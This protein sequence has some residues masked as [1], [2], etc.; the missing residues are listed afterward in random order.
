M[1]AAM[2]IRTGRYSEQGQWLYPAVALRLGAEKLPRRIRELATA[3]YLRAANIKPADDAVEQQAAAGLARVVETFGGL[4][5]GLD[6]RSSDR[7][8]IDRAKKI[9]LDFA[10][11]EVGM[12]PVQMLLDEAAAQGVE[13]EAAFARQLKVLRDFLSGEAERAIAV[14]G[15]SARL[16]DEQFW[17]RQLRRLVA[18]A[19]EKGMR[20]L[21]EVSRRRHLY[22]SDEAVRCRRNQRARNAAMMA[23]V[24]MVNELGQEFKLSELVEKSNANPAIRR[25][26]L[27]V[28]I[29][30]F[31]AVARDVGHVGEFITLTCPSRFHAM[32]ALSGGENARFDGSTPRDAAAYLQ[33]VWSRARAQMQRE[34]VEIYGFRVAEPHHDGTPHWHGL[35]FMPPEHRL[36]FRQILALHACRADRAELD[37]RYCQT[38]AEARAVAAERRAKMAAWMEP[39]GKKPPT[40]AALMADIKIEGDFWAGQDF[41]AWK[42]RKASRRVDFVEINWARGTA[43]GYIAKYIAKNIDGKTAAGDSAGVDFEAADEADFTETAERVDAW[44]ATWGIRQFQQIGGAP[45]TV[46]RELRRIDVSADDYNDVIVRAALAADKGDWGKFSAI[47][48]GGVAARADMP[49]ALYKDDAVGVNKY[50][51]PRQKS[52]RGV[53]EKDTGL[54]KISRIHEWVSGF[55][56]GKAAPWTCVNNCTNQEPPPEKVYSEAEIAAIIRTCEPVPL[57]NEHI[58]SR[59]EVARMLEE[60]AAD[61]ERQKVEAEWLDYR[62]ELAA[63]R[64]E[65]HKL[66]GLKGLDAG[67]I[68]PAPRGIGNDGRTRI[69]RLQPLPGKGKTDADIL[70][71][72]RAAIDATAEWMEEMAAVDLD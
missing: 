38:A 30:G 23:L 6:A 50:G 46:W 65:N 34:G 24:T 40:I 18:R 53:I 28:R 52:I 57:T 4:P 71:E 43:A 2:D 48:G 33:K 54:Y 11:R 8:I 39:L 27:M 35:F 70:A 47:M 49:L 13:V 7:D 64:A 41:K 15:I 9:A 58:L 66:Q 61:V 63:L 51:E 68:P 42:G 21:G 20:E 12:W 69:S 72:I 22:A 26:E 14:K 45:V 31:E 29:A 3:R 62:K 25:A 1:M 67:I 19:V 44:A 5:A 60:A 16:A 55:S 56:G 36:R 37:L 17:R 32:H 10:R 59:E